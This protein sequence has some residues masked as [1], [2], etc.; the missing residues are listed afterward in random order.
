MKPTGSGRERNMGTDIG[1][2]APESESDD[3]AL[4]LEIDS[5]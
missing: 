1:Q 3:L 4:S 2:G 5:K